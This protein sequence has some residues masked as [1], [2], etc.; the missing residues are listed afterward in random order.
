MPI[1]AEV[2]AEVMA[3]AQFHPA[4]A[5]IRQRLIAE[6][7]ENMKSSRKGRTLQRRIPVYCGSVIC[8]G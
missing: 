4:K 1:A 6:C 5:E 7:R 2:M 3:V 8:G